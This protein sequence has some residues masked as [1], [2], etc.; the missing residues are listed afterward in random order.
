MFPHTHHI[1]TMVLLVPVNK[2]SKGR[3]KMMN[4]RMKTQN[5]TQNKMQS[6]TQEKGASRG[7]SKG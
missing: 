2:S 3:P 4:D 7:K 6:K 5:N 1:E